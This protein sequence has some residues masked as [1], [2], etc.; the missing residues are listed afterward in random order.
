[1][2]SNGTS[3]SLLIIL[4]PIYS[5]QL[6]QHFSQLGYDVT[7]VPTIR[8]A[9]AH[10]RKHPPPTL[11]VSEFFQIYFHDRVSEVEAL[12]ATRDLLFPNTHACVIA[13]P[14]Q[15]DKVAQMCQ[16]YRVDE[17]FYQPLKPQQL[18]QAV[19]E[20]LSNIKP[21]LGKQA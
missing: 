16:R 4:N 5:G 8:K 18:I 12:L 20:L 17:V 7:C 21:S 13:T 11:I 15:K 10:T 19:T 2:T 6:Q 1:M 9:I 3:P 14:N